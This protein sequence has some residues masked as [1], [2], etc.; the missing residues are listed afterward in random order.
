M[1]NVETKREMS[2]Q[3]KKCR[4]LFLLTNSKNIGILQKSGNFI[5]IYIHFVFLSKRQKQVFLRIKKSNKSV[6][7]VIKVIDVTKNRKAMN[8]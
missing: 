8:K 5:Q 2:A 6:I 7:F 4:K 3:K 1:G